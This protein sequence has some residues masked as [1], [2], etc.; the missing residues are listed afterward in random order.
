METNIN[1]DKNMNIERN[2]EEDN[3]L[4]LS[5]KEMQRK[6]W[7]VPDFVFVT[8]DAYVDH[9]SFGTAVISR[10]LES[11]G[12]KVAILA[13]PDWR[14]ND[15]FRIFGRPRLGFLVTSG[16]ID[17]MVNHYTT[18]KRTRS[19]DLYS[20]GGGAGHRPDRAVM[21]YARKIRELFS[22]SPIII[23]GIEASLR[24]LA[25]YDYWDN[26]VRRSIL[27]DS[28]AD[29]LIY[30]MGEKQIVEIAHALESGIP[31]KDINFIKGTTWKTEESD[32]VLDEKAIMLPTYDDILASKEKYGE[33]YLLQY[34]NTD[35]ITGKT[36]IEPYKR[37]YV[38][39]NP[40]Q[41]PLTEKELD[42]IYSLPYARNYHPR[43]EKAGGIPAIKEVK[44]SLISS[45]GCFGGCNFC[46]L[47]YHQGRVVQSRSHE[48]LIVEAEKLTHEAD[49]KGYIH[50]VGGPTANFRQPS[51]TKQLKYGVCSHKQCLFPEPC[52][53]IEID[54]KDYLKL[55]T[56][57]KEIPG[58]K[59]VFIRSGIRY[60]YLMHDENNKEFFK[61][62]CEDHVSGQ[63]KVA[64]EHIS[65]NVLRMMGKPGKDVFEKFVKTFFETNKKV[66]KEQYL[67]PYLM[68]SHPGSTLN[69]AIEL[70]EYLRDSGYNPEQVQD[71]YPTPGTLSTCM[72]Y[73]ETDP[74]TKEKVYVPKT[75]EE[76]AMQRAL[77]QYKNPRN[78]QLVYKALM[79]A[80]RQDLIGFDKKSLIRPRPMGS[81]APQRKEKPIRE[82]KSKKNKKGRGR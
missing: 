30:G 1:I 60:D 36:L 81:K 29:L 21:V 8:G 72:Y 70:S 67:V 52:P 20:P 64:P 47:T 48:S 26:K 45:R 2:I 44:Y 78:Y 55:L 13:Q 37:R 65:D 39:V 59:K 3:F 18:A 76:K 16:N 57:L 10:L 5:R 23:G 31:V 25:H 58:I 71:F 11:H 80:E 35:S 77:I 15:N 24:R 17:S 46:A 41:D 82:N 79:Q 6:G 69:D 7:E 75:I 49:F 14:D 43:Y 19:E 56:K 38:V 9:P 28:Q 22:D 68:S 4:P 51:C 50:D 34:K 61:A 53:E 66:G 32:Y 74:R 27:L 33:S 54:H 63:L 12:Y 73:T 42:R 62:L 40:P